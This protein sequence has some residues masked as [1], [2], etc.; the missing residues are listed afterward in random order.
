MPYICICSSKR[1]LLGYVDAMLG[2]H[3]DRSYI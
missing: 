3:D 2:G 1:N